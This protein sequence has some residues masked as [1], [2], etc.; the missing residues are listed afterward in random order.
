MCGLFVSFVH[1]RPTSHPSGWLPPP[2]PSHL[3]VK[4]P[5]DGTP[6]RIR[7]GIHSG[8][9]MAGVV[10]NLMPR[11]CLF[12][13]TVNTASRM[14]SN[15]EA[16]RIHCS[17]ATADI[18]TKQGMHIVES[19][20]EIQIK[21]KG[22]MHTYWVTK[23]G[24]KNRA[25][26]DRAIE[27]VV[28]T[29][30]ELLEEAKE[31]R[32]VDPKDSAGHTIGGALAM[33]NKRRSSV[34]KT[35]E[36]YEKMYHT[37]SRANSISVR[38]MSKMPSAVGFRVSGRVNSSDHHDSEKGIG[39]PKIMGFDLGNLFGGR[40]SDKT[41]PTPREEKEDEKESGPIPKSKS[42]EHIRVSNKED[43]VPALEV[44]PARPSLAS[45][46]LPPMTVQPFHEVDADANGSHNVADVALRILVVMNSLMQRKLLVRQ[47]QAVSE[48]WQLNEAADSEQAL[49]KLK[50]VR[51]NYNVIIVDES[52]GSDS[53]RGHEFVQVR[54]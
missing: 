5:L 36:G 12:G 34:Q 32:L 49:T 1:R 4:S 22:L 14:E 25:A 33:Q 39:M 21:G 52:V 26:G 19:R 7:M 42:A 45:A 17:Q 31:N 48:A 27:G 18:L 37:L 13:D 29:V 15:G 30:R 10:G 54:D 35:A 44:L 24:P 47:L 40:K 51:G 41:L 23:A 46:H 43:F 53:L 11:Y 2:S 28:Q 3:Q 8:P 50:A 6:L 20:G 38:K 9:V 16:G